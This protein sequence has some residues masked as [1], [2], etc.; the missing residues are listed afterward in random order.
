MVGLWLGLVGFSL[1][2]GCVVKSDDDSGGSAG[3]A[4]DT[5]TGGSSTGGK[6]GSSTGGSSGKG[7][8]ATG[9]SSTGG[10]ATGGSSTGGSATGGTGAIGGADTDPECDP[11]T[12]ELDNTPYPNCTAA[13]GNGCEECIETSCC[14]ESMTCYGY[15]PGNV[16]GWGGPDGDGEI[17]CYVDCAQAY[18]DANGVLD[19][20]GKDECAAMCATT[21]CGLIGNATQ[22]LAACIEMNCADACWPAP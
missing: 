20:D 13:A 18:V 17:T 3:E 21:M 14:E 12:G 7:G 5:S 8:S 4:G 6:G 16:C 19:D 15:A 22:D 11:D 9:G 1:A 10:S 2:T